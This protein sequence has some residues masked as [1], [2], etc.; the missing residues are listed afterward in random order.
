VGDKDSVF[1][2]VRGPSGAPDAHDNIDPIDPE[3]EGDLGAEFEFRGDQ[4]TDEIDEVRKEATAHLET[5]QRVQAEFDNYR[6]RMAR[7]QSDALKRSGERIVVELLPVIDNLERAI[8]H[9]T[10][11][12]EDD[13][14]LPGVEMV[15][16]Q[17][18][19]VLLKEGVEAIDPSGQPFDAL[20]HQAVGQADNTDVPEGTVVEVYQKGYEMH[21]KI[22]RSAMV[23]VSHGGPAAEE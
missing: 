23:V 20:K 19:D 16:G 13:E 10:E 15:L 4:L 12:A 22:V 1:D 9:A 5:A 6:K 3:L 21:G 7:E 14:L 11:R 17:L 2:D 8:D 18:T